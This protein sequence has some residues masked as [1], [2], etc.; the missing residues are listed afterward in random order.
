MRKNW[1][2]LLIIMLIIMGASEDIV[3]QKRVKSASK[4]MQK[5][6]QYVSD[7]AQG[8][9]KKAQRSASDPATVTRDA[10][11]L[12]VGQSFDPL[13]EE[14][15]MFRQKSITEYEDFRRKANIEYAEF[16][17]K[18]WQ[19]FRAKPAIEKPKEEEKPPVVIDEKERQKPVKDNSLPIKETIE[20][21]VPEPQPKP[22]SPIREQTMPTGKWQTFS[23]YGTEMKVRFDDKMSFTLPSCGAKDIAN[24]WQK[25]SGSEYDNMIRDCLAIR[26][27]NQLSDWAY[28]NMLQGMA[29]ACVGKGN[30]AVLLM[31]FVY[32][33]SGY[34]MRL[35]VTTDG[36]LRMLYSTTHSIYD[37]AY[38]WIDDKDYYVFDGE[39]KSLHICNVSFPQEKSLSLYISKP[40][41]FAMRK[42]EART[43]ASARYPD[44]EIKVNVNKNLVD[45]YNDYP[46]SYVDGNFMTRW[47]I[48]ANTPL[49]KSVSDVLYPALRSKINGM[50]KKEAVERLL[51]WVQTAFVYGYDDKIWGGDRAFF[52][53]ETLFYPYCDC[54]DRS[55]L[56]S[57]LVRD[58]LGLKVVL[59][60]YPGHLASAV[61]FDTEVNGDYIML[62]GERFT[63]C[64][65]TYIGAPL[66]RTMPGMDNDKATVILLK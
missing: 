6:A 35:A 27:A 64:D 52:A 16:M 59:V 37:T 54:E 24:V 11:T 28:L 26:M 51:N 1:L 23:V 49:E 45:F 10:D 62:N 39:E 8:K 13:R 22:V 36:M 47:A 43:L 60:Y 42:S 20:P 2:K 30:E 3:A 15:E 7:K 12:E 33:Q 46:P 48:Y 63:I 57:R 41:K 5:Y 17:K 50:S 53:E 56:F 65:A 61:C 31:A 21:P 29:E 58:L 66:G 40:Q 34:Q 19:E 25:L 14:Y 38:F 44:M 9:E 55:I 18:A 4:A 32:C